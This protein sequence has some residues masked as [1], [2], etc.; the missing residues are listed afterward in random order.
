M[1][2]PKMSTETVCLTVLSYPAYSCMPLHRH[3]QIVLMSNKM[4]IIA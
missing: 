3:D 4:L 2:A 1:N